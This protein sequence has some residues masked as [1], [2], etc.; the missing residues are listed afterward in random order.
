MDVTKEQIELW[1]EEYKKVFKVFLDGVEYYYTT[2]KRQTYIDLLTKQATVPGFDY[3]FETMKSC[4]I[5]PPLTDTFKDDL[6][7]KSGLGVV[8]LEQIMMKSGW[9]QV[10]SEEL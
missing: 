4:V 5:H 2:L 7:N 1:K 10:E 3:E 8:L 9:Q 6:D